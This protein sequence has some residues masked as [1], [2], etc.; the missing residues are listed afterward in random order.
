MLFLL[1]VK[2]SGESCPLTQNT[3]EGKAVGKLL[4]FKINGG[5]SNF[6]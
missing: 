2:W 4:L 6:N 3:P 1:V 5:L